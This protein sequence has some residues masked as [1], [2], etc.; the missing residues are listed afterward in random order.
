MSIRRQST[1]TCTLKLSALSSSSASRL[2]RQHAQSLSSDTISSELAPRSYFTSGIDTV[3]LISSDVQTVCFF[4]NLFSEVLLP[5]PVEPTVR[6]PENFT[7]ETSRPP[8]PN[9]TDYPF[10]VDGITI[11]EPQS[12]PR[13]NLLTERFINNNNTMTNVKNPNTK[14]FKIL[15]KS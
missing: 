10:R 2:S 8:T 6:L 3:S 14:A 13:F 1:D 7:A 12:D 9:F 11:Y 5:T 15:T 4:G